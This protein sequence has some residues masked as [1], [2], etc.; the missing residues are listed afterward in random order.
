MKPIAVP[1]PRPHAT[2]RSKRPAR[3]VNRAGGTAVRERVQHFDPGRFKFQKITL[4][5]EKRT[6][7][8]GEKI[9]RWRLFLR[10]S[11]SG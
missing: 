6:Y 9:R 5:T 10:P 3:L 4:K 7:L 1:A 8:R 11:G 2:S